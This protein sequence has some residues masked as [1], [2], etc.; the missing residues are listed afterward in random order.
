MKN[1]ELVVKG[2]DIPANYLRENSPKKDR[3][4]F[5]SLNTMPFCNASCLY[6]FSGPELGKIPER[7]LHLREYKEVIE[8][9]KVLGAETVVFPGIGEPTLDI[10]LSNIIEFCFQKNLASVVYTN[11][12]WD[13]PYPSGTLRNSFHLLNFFYSHNTSLLIKIDTLKA[14]NYRYLTCSNYFEIFKKNL[15][16]IIGEYKPEELAKC[17]KN[18]TRL[19][20]C[21]V[22]TNI[23]KKDIREISNFCKEHRIK[24][25]VSNLAKV[26]YAENTWQELVGENKKELDRIVEK[27]STGVSAQTLDNRCGLFA[28][29]VTIDVNGDLIGCSTARWIRLGNIREKSLAELVKIYAEKIH[30]DEERFCLGREIFLGEN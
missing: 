20:A 11:G 25:F 15:D 22:V 5:L 3:I 17:S 16:E 6:C 19:G 2:F 23:N 1:R 8:Q 24:H 29:G 10:N 21:T 4:S 27:Y 9:A 18:L 28:Y 7:P 13:T 14:G 30:C 12:V 26:G